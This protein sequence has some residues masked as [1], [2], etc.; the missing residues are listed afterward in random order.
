[1]KP[2][3]SMTLAELR[4]IAAEHSVPGRSKLRKAAL[5][6]AIE[7]ARAAGPGVASKM[8][9]AAPAKAAR[10]VAAGV[11]TA[12]SKPAQVSASRSAAAASAAQ[13]SPS[14]QAPTKPS[15]KSAGSHT[16]D[17]SPLPKRHP[18]EHSA[19]SLTPLDLG[20][21]PIGYDRDHL[22]LKVQSP[23]TLFCY[24][25][26]HTHDA[27]VMD[28]GRAHIRLFDVTGGA[29][30]ELRSVAVEPS[31][32]RWFIHEL[33]PDREYR[34]EFGVLRDD[35]FRPRL[36]SAAVRTPPIAHS[37]IDDVA[38]V[39]LAFRD[40]D[41]PA[42]AEIPTPIFHPPAAPSADLRSVA[43][44]RPFAPGPNAGASEWDHGD[45]VGGGEGSPLEVV[46]ASS[47]EAPNAYASWGSHSLG[48]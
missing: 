21:I 37:R 25:S 47:S 42:P 40:D 11:G 4:K 34:V 2:L 48:A 44:L 6:K 8:P 14:P 46:P 29:T 26:L 19:P 9:S 17:P 27:A 36:S 10:P 41:R 35:G 28:D 20:G 32:G 15:P 38:L 3:T 12:G 5:I 30:H 7:E 39:T 24:W 45:A 16:P 31:A 23:D 33:A 13:T 43:G 18:F 1:M 22:E